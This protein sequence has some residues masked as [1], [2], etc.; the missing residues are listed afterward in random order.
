M[1][2]MWRARMLRSCVKASEATEI[3]Y[4]PL[5]REMARYGQARIHSRLQTTRFPGAPL[6]SPRRRIHE[7]GISMFNGFP[8]EGMTREMIIACWL[9]AG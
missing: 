6:A 9:Q 4:V 7:H 2:G 1:L 5:L 8:P 3:E